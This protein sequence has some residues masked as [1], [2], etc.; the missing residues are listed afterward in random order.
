M[1]LLT[2]STF[3][4]TLETA[5]SFKTSARVLAS[6]A[7]KEGTIYVGD[8]NGSF[9]AIDGSSGQE[10]WSFDTD[11][12]IQA[13]A[14]VTDQW[15][16]FES[17]NVFYLLKSSNGKE[18]WR[19]D[20]EM[21]PLAFTYQ[22]KTYPYKIDPFDDKRS[23]ATLLDGVIY[24]GS[25]NGTLFGLNEKSGKVEFSVRSDDNSPIRSSPLVSNG[26]LF[27]GDWN[28][29]VY[30]YDLA[31]GEFIWKKKT[32]R[33][34]LYETFGGVVSEFL[35]YDSLLFFGARNH[36]M[37]VLDVRTGEK[38]WTYTD[39][40]GGWMIGD[41]V[42][43]KDTLYIGGSDNFSMFAFQ[44]TMGRPLWNQNGGKNIY[45][46]PILTE[47]WLLYT[48][49]NSYN[50][51]DTGKLFLLDRMSGE[52]LSSIEVPYAVFSSPVLAENKVYFG[53]YDE[54]VYCVEIKD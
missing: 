18:L 20:T 27:F 35:E 2:A 36:M 21:E 38:E 49:G 53:C 37:N 51:R 29:V 25:G 23:S 3:S 22:E 45:T 41:P 13:K 40:N 12:I 44:P 9:Y 10:R 42:I 8:I 14:L 52:L 34:K 50:S 39:A 26:R 43:F 24:V 46:K 5:W 33:Q 54:N 30:C 7:E 31:A 48:A 6:P 32:Y 15:V 19:F 17:A 28:G 11:G 1:S 47:E 16:F 4:Q